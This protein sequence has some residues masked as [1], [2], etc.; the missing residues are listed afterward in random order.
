MSHRVLVVD[1]DRA[2][3]AMFTQALADAGFDAY[4]ATSV[5]E[6][7]E[8]IAK[9]GADVVVLDLLLKDGD[10][11]VLMAGI[12]GA[13]PQ[14]RI[15][16]ATA[17]GAMRQAATALA[18]GAFDYLV[19]P[20]DPKRLI[21]VVENAAQC[22]TQRQK[23]E[24]PQAIEAV[25]GPSL[26]A[27]TRALHALAPLMIEGELGTGKSEVAAYLHA[28]SARAQLPFVSVDCAVFDGAGIE[29]LCSPDLLEHG[30]TLVLNDPQR[31]SLYVQ[32]QVLRFVQSC[33]VGKTDS[34]II[35]LICCMAQSP[36]EAVDNGRFREDLFYR[37]KALRI[38]LLPLRERSEEIAALAK[39]VLEAATQEDGR[40]FK[41]LSDDAM[42]VLQKLQWPGNLAQLRTVVG[43]ISE[44]CSA[45]E[46]TPDLLPRDILNEYYDVLSEGELVTSDGLEGNA[47][48]T[49][50]EL[51]REGWGLAGLERLIVETTI[52]ENGG[53]IP[54]AAKQ[55]Q[56]SPSTLYRKLE[57][58]T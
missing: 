8:V 5:P 40:G 13:L 20:I 50:S 6:A 18:D 35:R 23:T 53:S 31:L 34:P 32:S 58:W 56:V 27:T 3:A 46:V 52:S 45:S 41:T 47:S 24:I 48:S 57:K 19:K 11:F 7:A 17:N 36:E 10:A 26:E 49:V 25:L 44:S 42:R 55:L 16:A 9:R 39:S 37:L 14:T 38:H 1:Q 15:V 43:Q 22:E 4:C 2:Q 30:G 28:A 33:T 29:D 54:K 21:A 51:I 12:I